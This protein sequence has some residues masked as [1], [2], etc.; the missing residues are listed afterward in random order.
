MRKQPL[1]QWYV[2]EP[3][4]FPG[5]EHYMRIFWDLSTERQVGVAIGQIPTGKIE[6]YALRRGWGAETIRV[7]KYLMRELDAK[8]LDWALKER[9]KES[10]G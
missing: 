6:E 2:D 9:K 7:L 4:A 1:P 8:Y 5:T 10:N 3:D